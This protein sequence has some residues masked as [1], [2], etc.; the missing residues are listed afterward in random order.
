MHERRQFEMSRWLYLCER[1]A[2]QWQRL[3]AS[4]W[5]TEGEGFVWT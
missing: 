4:Y 1:R 2:R 3:P 5:G